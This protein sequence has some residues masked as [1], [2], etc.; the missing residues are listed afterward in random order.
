LVVLCGLPRTGK[1]TAARYLATTAHATVLATDDVRRQLFKECSMQELLRADDP[2]RYDIQRLFDPLPTIP[3]KYQQLIWKQNAMTYEEMVRKIPSFLSRGNTILDGSFS[4]K[5]V[6]ERAYSIARSMGHRP[7]LV[8]CVCAESVV[9]RRLERT[10]VS[11]D[12]SSNVVTFDVYIKVKERFEVP[13]KDDVTVFT[14]DSGT[15]SAAVRNE[16]LGAETE[17]AA[18]DKGL[19]SIVVRRT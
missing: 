18:I 7:Y 13:L 15:N 16:H 2:M 4:R 3:D 19:R 14:Y 10:N 1:T 12:D 5:S 17:M 8:Y 6:R 11:T 9:R